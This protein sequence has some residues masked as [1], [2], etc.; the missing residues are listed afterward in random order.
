[1]CTLQRRNS[2]GRAHR[3]L[4]QEGNL[5]PTLQREGSLVVTI[6]PFRGR[7][8]RLRFVTYDLEWIPR[9]LEERL[10]GIYDGQ[11]YRSYTSTLEFLRTELTHRNRGKAFFAHAGGMAD[12]QFVLKEI[13][14]RAN[15]AFRVSG[16]WSGSSLVICRISAGQNAWTFVDSYWL[17]RDKL[18]KIGESI[19][20]GKGGGEYRCS[21]FPACGHEEKMC[22]FYSPLAVLKDYNALD[23]RI[24]YAAIERFQD[25]VF[26]LGGQI[27]YT[28]AS[29][30][31]MLFRCAYLHRKIPTSQAINVWC[32]EGYIASRVEVI[33]RRCK[34]ADYYDINSSFPYSMTKSLP[35]RFL[36]SKKSFVEGKGCV[37]VDATI[38]IPDIMIPPVPYRLDDRVYFPV[39]TFRNRFF[40]ED[41]TLLL[42]SGGTID[43]VHEVLEFEPFEDMASYV[44]SIYEL[45]KRTTDSFQKLVYKYLMNCLYGKFG[46]GED[47][48]KLLINPKRRPECGGFEECVEGCR[49][50]HTYRAG[51]Y[52]VKERVTLKHTHVPIAGAITSSS[53]AIITRK[54]QE[55]SQKGRVYYC[56]T[57][58]LVTTES[59]GTSD[60][61]GALKHEKS[62]E[63]GTFLA[64][65]LYR[66]FPSGKTDPEIRAKGFRSL[67]SSE[68]D[69]LERGDTVTIRRM[70]RLRE[71]F[72]KGVFEPREEEYLKRTLSHLGPQMLASLGFRPTE[73]LRPKRAFQSDGTTR[74]WNVDELTEPF[75]ALRVKN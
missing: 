50:I 38:T 11:E 5:P 57:D 35:G 72:S 12:I 31:L 47:K 43:Y 65:K 36:R 15:P 1:M 61:L 3:L 53:R 28:I 33:E 60:E 39:G 62:I 64:P 40:G 14:A 73:A 7:R 24:L 69:A 52:K 21:D 48:F 19:G 13:I 41:L 49:C 44:F 8:K 68:F 71:N 26:S 45:R 6:E 46:E 23:C 22:I 18:A 66:I 34:K 4:S 32:R 54:L 29:T 63:K 17:F 20:M 58:S 74:P 37:F 25:E 56:D 27:R 59:L 51:I 75:G 70:V 10:V 42:D 55:A 2:S 16:H 30:G 67:T 9:T